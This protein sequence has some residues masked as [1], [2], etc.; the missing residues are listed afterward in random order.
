ME[1]IKAYQNIVFLPCPF[2]GSSVINFDNDNRKWGYVECECGA[3]GPEIRTGYDLSDQAK[4]R[5]EAVEKWNKRF[6]PESEMLKNRET[7][8]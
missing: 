8:G 6:D 4:W 5:M 1:S 3:R 2:C 7:T